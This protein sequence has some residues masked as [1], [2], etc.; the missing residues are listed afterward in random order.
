[1]QLIRFCNMSVTTFDM[2]GNA[3][4]T[5]LIGAVVQQK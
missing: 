1:M 4:T 3:D 5:F 2:T